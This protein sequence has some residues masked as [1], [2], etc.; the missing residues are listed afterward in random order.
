MDVLTDVQKQT[1]QQVKAAATLWDKGYIVKVRIPF[2]LLGFVGAPIEEG[3]IVEYGCTVV[4]RDIDNEFRPENISFHL[5]FD[6][7]I[8]PVMVADAHAECIGLWRGAQYPLCR[9]DSR[10]FTRLRILKNTCSKNK[11]YACL[12]AGLF[13]LVQGCLLQVSKEAVPRLCFKR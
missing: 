5:E 10:P 12:V 1:I 2:Q 7:S 6:N 13:L 4:V 9:C 8:L 11:K 3:K